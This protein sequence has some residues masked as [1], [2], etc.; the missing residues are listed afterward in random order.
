MAKQV[1]ERLVDDIDGSEANQSVSFSVDGHTYQIDLN[2]QH[3]DELRAKLQPFVGVARRVRH[4]PG[5]TRGAGRGIVPDKDR[6]SAI[7]RW[8]LD[9]GV[10]LPTRG[11]IAGAV[12]AAY[13]ARDVDALYTATGLEREAEPAPKPTRRRAPGAAFSATE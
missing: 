1:I 9:E 10:E 6:N 4:Q 13:D 8:A 3:A 7:R 5:P 2:E 12:Q 11:R